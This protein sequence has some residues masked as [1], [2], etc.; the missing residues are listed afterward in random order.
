MLVDD[1]TSANAT[2]VS[3]HHCRRRLGAYQFTEFAAAQAAIR[4]GGQIQELS[5]TLRHPE[6]MLCDL[7]NLDA[8]FADWPTSAIEEAFFV[9]DRALSNT[10][11]PEGF[12]RI[13]GDDLKPEV[14]ISGP[15]HSELV[16]WK[17]KFL[18]E[19][20]ASFVPPPVARDAPRGL[21]RSCSL[22][23]AD[24]RI[25]RIVRKF[26][27]H[28]S[29][30]VHPAYWDEHPALNLRRLYS[31]HPVWQSIAALPGHKLYVLS[32]GLA[33][34]ASYMAATGDTNI[35]FTEHHRQND[36]NQLSRICSLT[37]IFPDPPDTDRWVIVDKSYSGGTIEAA[38]AILEA[39]LGRRL[40]ITKVAL[41][42]K[43][44]EGVKRADYAVYAGRLF[45]CNEVLPHLSADAWHLELLRAT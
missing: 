21:H 13:T 45:R 14:A 35:Y 41:F 22:I 11:L 6:T 32:A 30:F 43:S 23:D 12:R 7:S 44:L 25:Q 27:L 19:T 26:A 18:A 37:G 36:P 20:L 33:I 4:V 39:R 42:P 9:I 28:Y 16:S 24:E 29:Q 5:L 34:G 2:L 40:D 15:S 10:R 8:P 38:A 17:E 3:E 31:D 1:S